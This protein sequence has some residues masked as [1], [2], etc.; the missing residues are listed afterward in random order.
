MQDKAHY[1]PIIVIF[2]LMDGS[3]PVF[4]FERSVNSKSIEYF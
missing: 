4:Y 2:F 1:E 3:Y